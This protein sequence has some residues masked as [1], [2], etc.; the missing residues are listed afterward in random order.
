MSPNAQ[1]LPKDKIEYPP[2]PRG[3]NAVLL[4]PPGSGKGTQVILPT[5]VNINKNTFVEN[6]NL[7]TAGMTPYGVIL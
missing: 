4:G 1:V 5:S 3:V 2:P 6:I 7:L